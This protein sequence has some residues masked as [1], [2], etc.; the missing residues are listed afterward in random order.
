[1][2]L[3]DVLSSDSQHIKRNLNHFPK[4]LPSFQAK[5]DYTPGALNLSIPY[6][7]PSIPPCSTPFQGYGEFVFHLQKINMWIIFKGT[8]LGC[9]GGSVG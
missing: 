6:H 2:M 5:G 4:G 1:M 9:M 7:L 3:F 8:F